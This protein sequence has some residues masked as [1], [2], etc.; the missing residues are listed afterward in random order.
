MALVDIV[1]LCEPLP[2]SF[3][4]ERIS[5]CSQPQATED[6]GTLKGGQQTYVRIHTKILVDEW[7]QYR[8]V[9]IT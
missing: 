9:T 8:D 6:T 3:C 7:D 5:V 4:N 2:T 1:V